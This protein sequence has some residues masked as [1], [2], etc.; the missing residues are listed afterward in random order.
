MKTAN[1]LLRCAL[2]AFLLFQSCDGRQSDMAL[3][4]L[5]DSPAVKSSQAA[6]SASAIFTNP[7]PSIDNGN[8]A[9]PWVIRA[10]GFY[11]YCGSNGGSLF[12]TK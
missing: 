4:K 5:T 9:D 8:Y 6:L 3:N 10:G 12:I 7:L 1:L 2:P 11:Y